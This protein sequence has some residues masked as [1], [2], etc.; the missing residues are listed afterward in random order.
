MNTLS[1][2]ELAKTIVIERDGAID[3]NSLSHL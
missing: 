1:Q 3:Q 2:R